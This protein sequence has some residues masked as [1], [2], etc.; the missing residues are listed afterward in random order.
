[1]NLDTIPSDQ[2]ELELLGRAMGKTER[3]LDRAHATV[4]ALH[5]KITR[6]QIEYERQ[7]RR[8]DAEMNSMT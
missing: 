1:M 5:A 4:R 2:L 6:Q 3:A 8:I 7:T